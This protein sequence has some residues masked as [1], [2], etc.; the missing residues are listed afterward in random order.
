VNVPSISTSI[1]EFA[2][3][4]Y[5][6]TA[7]GHSWSF[8]HTGA[9]LTVEQEMRYLDGER[10]RLPYGAM[11]W[12]ASI[13]LAQELLT[14]AEALR[15][16]R[17]LEIGA[18]TGIPG[19][20]A[21]TL[22]ARVLQIDRSEI[23]LHLCARNKERNRATT[24]EVR[25]ADWDTFESDTQFDL[26]LGA[27]VLYATTMHARLRAICD[28]YLAPG[29]RVLFSDPLRSQGLSMLE[30]M[31]ASGWRVS[32]SKWSIEVETGVR[33]IAVYEATRQ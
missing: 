24:A 19:I 2:L 9:V 28:D 22:G 26:I 30:A 6:L 18:G 16:R 5:C 15:G 1:G 4:E 14:D 31:A 11:L 21:A 32:L 20:V 29:G 3:C 17:V 7:G 8:F 23:A 25:D 33:A 27:D 13:A 10:D 12:P